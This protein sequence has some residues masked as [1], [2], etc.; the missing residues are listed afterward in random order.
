MVANLALS[1]IYTMFIMQRR[2]YED[3]VMRNNEIF[4]ELCFVLTCT[5]LIQYQ[6]VFDDYARKILDY[7]FM[8]SMAILLSGNICFIVI[9]IK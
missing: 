1:L 7:A 9:A 5:I 4:T 3:K 2:L 6:V 8:G